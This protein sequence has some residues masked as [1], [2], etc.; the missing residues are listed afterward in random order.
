V[1]RCRFRRDIEVHAITIAKLKSGAYSD[2]Y[3][4]MI[5]SSVP[6]VAQIHQVLAQEG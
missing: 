1:R 6:M 2:R 4:L 3:L 5:F